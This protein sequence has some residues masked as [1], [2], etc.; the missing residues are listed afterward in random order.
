MLAS[1]AI[2]VAGVVEPNMFGVTFVV[3]QALAVTLLQVSALRRARE[4]TTILSNG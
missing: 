1:F 4:A 3:A 2:L